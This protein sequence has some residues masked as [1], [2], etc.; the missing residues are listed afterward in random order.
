VLLILGSAFGALATAAPAQADVE[1]LC[2][3]GVEPNPCHESLATT[4]YSDSGQASVDDPPLPANPPIDCFYVYPTVSEQPGTNANKDKDPQLNEIARY[5]A[6]RYSQQCRVYA[7]VYRQLT[8]LSINAA[9]AEQRAEGGKLAYGDVREA[10]RDYLAH[11]NHGRGF[12]LIGHSQGTRM[13]RQLIRE[14]VDPK[15]EVRRR[16]VSAILLGGNVLVR[17]GQKIGGDFRNIPA[18][19]APGQPRCV[20]AWSTFNDPP[21]DNSRFGRSPPTDPTGAGFPAGPDYE[22]LCTNPASL[23]ANERKALTTY[24]RSE[25]FPGVLGALLVEM[26]GGP[27]PTAPTPWLQP[28]EHYSGR[29]EQSAGANVLMLKSIGNAR[30]LNPAPDSSWGLHL[31]DANIALGELV[32][33]VRKAGAKYVL[34]RTPRPR[35]V[36][37]RMRVSAKRRLR[38]TIACRADS[39]VVCAGRVRLRAA[40]RRGLGF[41]SRR[42]SVRGGSRRRV[43]VRVPRGALA[44]LRR[45]GSRRVAADLIPRGS[46]KGVYRAVL[47]VR[48]PSRRG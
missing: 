36:G 24:L 9:T 46:R 14:E 28:S 18:C 35:I 7:P 2:R 23:G 26:Y 4:V 45:W 39:D 38:L 40:G 11:H 27:P 25:P 44:L 17:K 34:G 10:W 31:A 20:M 30:K 6:A 37:R 42:Y 8:L 19:T 29:C 48:A 43:A 3:P 32:D 15:P 21:P 12:V 33:E 47:R 5:Q 1:W 22:V 16:L 41:G 13:L